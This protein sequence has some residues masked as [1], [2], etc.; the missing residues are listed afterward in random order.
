M[1]KILILGGSGL[2]GSRFIELTSAT[3]QIDSPSHNNL[4]LLNQEEIANYLGNSDAEVVLNLVAATNVDACEEE[5]DDEGGS[6][7]FLNAMTPLKLAQECQRTGKHLI[8]ISTDY[9]FDGEKSDAPYTE[10]DTPNP[11]NWYGKTK[12]IGEQNVLN[13][14]PEFTVVRIEMPYSSHFEKKKD[15]ARFF[16]ESLQQGKE[17]KSIEDQNITP[18]FVDDLVKALLKFVEE[19]PAGIWHVAS[20]DSTTPYEFAQEV[21][22]QANL[23]PELIS[24]V[25][26][27][28]FNVGRKAS[29]PHHSWMSVKKF[30]QR[31]GTE[32]LE[33]NREG[34]A[35][36]LRSK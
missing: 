18:I 7:Y 29:R 8:H 32:V 15:F 9:V 17:F 19:K 6:V 11:V 33:K 16:L 14:D 34:I 24:P 1:K 30:E 13:V 2:V 36:F 20:A 22:R 26:F 21:A 31:F 28:E 35:N 12:L 3:Y 27:A 23:S 25:K 4:D 5:K 10:E